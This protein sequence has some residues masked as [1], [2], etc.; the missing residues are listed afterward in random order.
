MAYWIRLPDG[1]YVNT[2]TLSRLGPEVPPGEDRGKGRYRTFATQAG[3]N[4]Q[5]VEEAAADALAAAI[6]AQQQQPLAPPTPSLP[7]CGGAAST[8]PRPRPRPRRSRAGFP[9]KPRPRRPPRRRRP[10]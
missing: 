7:L 8:A 9:T 10:G 1:S 5:I 3:L 6:E 4:G 2:D